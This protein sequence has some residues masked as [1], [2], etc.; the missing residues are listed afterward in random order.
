M[1]S[2]DHYVL[3][4]GPNGIWYYYVY[5]WG[6]KVR[7]S[8]G[9]RVKYRA[10][11]FCQKLRDKGDLLNE[12]AHTK[13]T[14]FSEFSAPF[15]I[16]ET[17]PIIRDKIERGGHFSRALAISNRNNMNKYLLPAFGTKVLPEISPATIK[18]WLRS[19]PGKYGIKPQ[20]ANKLLTMLRQILDVAVEE[21]LLRTNPARSVK[22]LIPT[23]GTKGCFTPE[24]VKALF[25]DH[26][27]NSYIEMMCRLASITGMRLGEIKGLCF[28]QVKQDHIVL[29]RA[30]AKDEGLKSTKSGKP[31]IVPI[32][33][34]VSCALRAFPRLGDIIFTLNGEKPFD[35][36]SVL[37]A[38]RKR[39]D[40]LNGKAPDKETGTAGLFFD[41][42]NKKEPLTFHSFRHFLN[43]RLLA[44]GIQGETIR[45]MIG[46]EDEAMTDLY[47]HLSAEDCDRI[48]V[49]Q[50]AI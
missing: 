48:R 40:E 28:D 29:D 17:C 21:Q 32:P 33:R 26:W 41:Y 31:R 15:W 34:D 25:R 9:E 4:K 1:R 30:W 2:E 38:L 10:Q 39:M 20:T 44:A 45:A 23:N 5:R 35:T 22:P 47:A 16:W 49:I 14:T 24:Q 50:Q 19:I 43:S 12:Q 27:K 3:Y 11:E 37:Y 18:I 46:H 42:L 13:F 8:T 36:K 7:R 6:K